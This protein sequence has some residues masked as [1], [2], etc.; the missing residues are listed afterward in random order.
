LFELGSGVFVNIGGVETGVELGEGFFNEDKVL[1]GEEM[2][3]EVRAGE[4]GEGGRADFHEGV[5]VGVVSV[6]SGEFEELRGC[7]GIGL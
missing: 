5:Q 7:V 3:L 6:A 2:G 1:R 4:I